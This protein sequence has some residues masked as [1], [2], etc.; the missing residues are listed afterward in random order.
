MKQLC[1]I[2]NRLQ[3]KEMNHRLA[4]LYGENDVE[5]QSS[6]Y[7]KALEKYE[8]LFGDGE[9]EIYS[10]PGRTEIGGNHT[11]HQHG[12]VL[13]GAVNLDTIAVVGFHE[14]NS[15]ELVSEGYAPV[16]IELEGLDVDKDAY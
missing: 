10:A 2:K 6:R 13:A 11:D 8:E 3:G 15:I 1:E 4:E 16:S 12:R 7:L 9:V 5:K 14:K